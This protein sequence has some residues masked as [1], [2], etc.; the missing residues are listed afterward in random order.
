MASEKEQEGKGQKRKVLGLSILLVTSVFI[1]K[2][3]FSFFTNSLSFFTELADGIMD[4]FIVTL[5]FIALRSSQKP[6]DHDHMFGHYK[7]NSLIAVIQSL[8]TMG[9]YIWIFILSISTIINI[10]EYQIQNTILIIIPLSVIVVLNFVLT[11]IIIKIGNKSNNVAIKAQAANFKGDFFRN[12]SI[13]VGLL[14]TLIHPLFIVIDPILAVLFS[15][16]SVIENISILKQGFNELMDYNAIDPEK[17]SEF[18]K[19]MKNIEGIYDFR[20]LAMRTAGKTIEA[21]IAVSLNEKQSLY[22]I[23]EVSQLINNKISS[24]FPSYRSNCIIQI[25]PY[26]TN[27]HEPYRDIIEKV[28]AVGKNFQNIKSIHGVTLDVMI[29]EILIQFHISVDPDLKLVDAH[30][31]ASELEQKIEQEIQNIVKKLQIRVDSHIEPGEKAQR[32]HD[33]GN[34]GNLDEFYEQIIINQ[35]KLLPEIKGFHDL[36]IMDE[37]DGIYL[38]IHIYLDSDL[39]VKDA[40]WTSEKLEF[41]LKGKIPNLK[42]CVIHTE[43]AE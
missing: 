16:K 32:I 13:I 23:S 6:A 18:E 33:H 2:F 8:V 4:F 21:N 25:N 36:S 29:D 9:V 38:S 10:S 34:K 40:H 37:F 31:I 19:S 28:I 11:R 1:I 42:R 26:A 24:F 3:I 41:Y 20:I 5:T 43:P 30:S 35:I 7:V 39:S 15:I 22:G 27:I 17:I 12:I 14:I